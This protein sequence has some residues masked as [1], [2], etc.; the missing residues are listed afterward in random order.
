M[1][2]TTENTFT[3]DLCKETFVKGWTDEEAM[4][5]HSEIFPE[6]F[7]PKEEHACICDDCFNEF[8][9]WMDAGQPSGG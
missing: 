5:E 3:C 9:A 2:T 7:K 8:M 4:E 6:S 1:S